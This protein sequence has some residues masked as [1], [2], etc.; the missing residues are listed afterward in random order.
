MVDES[1]ISEMMQ[2]EVNVVAV[3]DPVRMARR[4]MES[5]ALR[6]LLVVDGDRPVGVIQWVD[7]LKDE[8]TEAS[9]DAP[10]G[11]LMVREFPILTTT[12]TVP[13]ARQQLGDVNVDILPVVDESGMLV[14][15]VRRQM[16]AQ[17]NETVDG[18]HG[19]Q[20]PMGAAATDTGGVRGM[21]ADAPMISSGM[22]VN[23]EDGK[24]LG[25]VDQI[26][27][28]PNGHVTGFTVTHGFISK[29][30]KRVPYDIIDRIEG[31]NVYTRIGGMEFKMLA[32]IEDEQAE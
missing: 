15:Q 29:K 21:D 20:E 32:D 13:E 2:P 28:D 17:H 31:D 10:V 16:I 9:D 18:A 26:L 14:G 1:H 24:K 22:T 12:M 25:E 30:H 4:R 5:E 27:V 23:G 3:S 6:S 11:D 8:R 7:L 19:S